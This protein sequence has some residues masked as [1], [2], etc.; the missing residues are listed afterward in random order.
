MLPLLNKKSDSS[1]L[2]DITIREYCRY[3]YTKY[4]DMGQFFLIVLLILTAMGKIIIPEIRDNYSFYN[5]L[6]KER[7]SIFDSVIGISEIRKNQKNYLINTTE[8]KHI[9]LTDKIILTSEVKINNHKY[10]LFKLRY[11]NLSETPFFH[12]DS[13]G[14]THRNYGNENLP[15]KE[16]QVT[17]PH[18][19]CFNENGLSVAYKTD[20]LL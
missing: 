13:D 10:F 17:T 5:R 3:K 12:Y 7:K 16:Q 19:N 4:S 6:L 20:K 8:V 18:F 1:Q 9:Q 14:A 15:L 2:S 11:I